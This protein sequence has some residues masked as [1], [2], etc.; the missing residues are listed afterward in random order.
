[1]KV[2]D[3][4]KGKLTGQESIVSGN[5]VSA[6][7]SKVM[8]AET[9]DTPVINKVKEYRAKLPMPEAATT[10]PVRKGIAKVLGQPEAAGLFGDERAESSARP[11]G[12]G[13]IFGR[14]LG[15]SGMYG[16][17]LNG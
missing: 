9:V 17:D 6:V 14:D 7:K 8:G 3:A 13:G 4:I 16:R 1:M 10:G 2:L 11:I 15:S 12:L 5:V